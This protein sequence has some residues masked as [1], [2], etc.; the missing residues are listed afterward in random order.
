MHLQAEFSSLI[1]RNM[2]GH[3]TMSQSAGC[4]FILGA[5][6]LARTVEMN[7]VDALLC[8]VSA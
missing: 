7:G 6:P 8:E 5:K 4:T 2:F 1:S 3:G